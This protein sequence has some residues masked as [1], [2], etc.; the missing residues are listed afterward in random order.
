ML[1]GKKKVL[2]KEKRDTE[3]GT[4]EKSSS[5]LRI[6]SMLGVGHLLA[7]I[8]RNLFQ[9]NAWTQ[10]LE[11]QCRQITCLLPFARRDQLCRVRVLSL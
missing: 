7:L 5:K 10:T 3:Q 8:A 1:Q 11:A 2:A 6:C 9:E 4:R